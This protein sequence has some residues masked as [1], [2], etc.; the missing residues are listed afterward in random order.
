MNAAAPGSRE[1]RPFLARLMTKCRRTTTRSSTPVT[2]GFW[3]RYRDVVRRGP[4]GPFHLTR[5]N[6]FRVPRTMRPDHR[7]SLPSMTRPAA[8]LIAA[9]ATLILAGCQKPT[10]QAEPPPPTVGVVASRRMTVPIL[11]TPN[12]TTR[13]LEDVTIRAR[14]R[15]FL[16]ERHFQEGSFVKE[17]QLLLVIDEEPYRIALQSARARLDEAAAALEKAEKSKGREVTAAQLALDQAQLDL[18]RAEEKRER[19]LLTRNAATLEDVDRRVA[20]RKKYEAQ[21]EADRANHEQAK[22][23]YEVGIL[24]A[25]AQVEAAQAAV[26]DAELN[27]G[28]CRMYAPID[29][30][31]G[32]A[33]VKVGNLVGPESAGGGSF[34]ELATIQQLDPM[35]VDIQVS[36]RYLDRATELI[37]KGLTVRV[38]RPGLKGEQEHPYEGVFYFIDNRIVETTS[39]F[40]SKARVPNPQGSLLPG[41]YVK[42]RIVVDQLENAVVVPAPA[43]AETEAGPVVYIVDGRG[44]VAV[45]R[46]EAA[47]TY[48][49]LRIITRGLDAGVPVIVE[50]LQMIRPGIPVKTEPAVLPRPARDEAKGEAPRPPAE[51]DAA[52][53]AKTKHSTRPVVQPGGPRSAVEEAEQTEQANRPAPRPGATPK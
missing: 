34:T 44:K 2:P 7:L 32:E 45:Q 38:I 36:S 17:G 40:L 41:E 33:L 8:C 23:D 52:A 28:Y 53:A 24:S 37:Q 29:G 21:V 43:V 15:G 30:R 25:R 14:V 5:D 39:T 46:V 20:E 10:A 50:G 6:P 31:V 35:G 9:V 16:T 18:A 3:T 11:A 49:G 4:R 13:A 22:A 19:S 48:E 51:E 12:G 27:L 47:Q 26:R 1:P 42:L